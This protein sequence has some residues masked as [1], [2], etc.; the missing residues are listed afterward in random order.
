MPERKS[1]REQDERKAIEDELDRELEQT[2]PAS[3]APKVTRSPPRTRITPKLAAPKK[4]E[5]DR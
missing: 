4:T 2:F 5:G 3:D 1:T